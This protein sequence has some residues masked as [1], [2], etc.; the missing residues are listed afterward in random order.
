[1]SATHR[2]FWTFWSSSISYIRQ[3]YFLDI[4]GPN[5]T[6]QWYV[7]VHSFMQGTLKLIKLD[8]MYIHTYVPNVPRYFPLKSV[9]HLHSQFFSM[10]PR[11][12]PAYSKE[13]FALSAEDRK[14]ENDKS[15]VVYN[16]GPAIKAVR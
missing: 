13:S 7:Y 10:K 1:V 8:Y 2:D 6:I 12:A 11:Q 16:T 5:T 15:R 3:S 14:L 4:H 9:A